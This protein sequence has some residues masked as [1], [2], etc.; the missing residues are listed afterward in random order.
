MAITR[1]AKEQAVTQLQDE[2]AQLKLVVLTDYRGLSV[3]EISE[4]RAQLRAEGMSYRVTKNTLL[5]IAAAGSP[6]LKDIDPEIFTGPMA[7]ALSTTDEVAPARVIFQYA[8]DHKA[9]EIVGAITGDGELLDPAQVKALATLPTREQLLAQV[10]GTIAAPLS[11]FVG[12]MG[13][14]VRGIVTVL[15][16]IKE[17]KE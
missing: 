13:A 16:A 11:G 1:A 15:N 9:L 8:K 12:V 10:V 14:N 5:R 7:L 3:S 4:L 17:T 6:K 2:L